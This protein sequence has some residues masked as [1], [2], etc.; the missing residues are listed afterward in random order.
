MEQTE[1]RIECKDDS[2]KPNYIS[3]Q[4]KYKIQTSDLKENNF[5]I[6]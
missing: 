1:N 3:T 6:I 2:F 5:Q 4:M